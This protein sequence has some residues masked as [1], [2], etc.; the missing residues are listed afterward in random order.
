MVTVASRLL[1]VV[2]ESSS[3]RL[4]HSGDPCLEMSGCSG[5]GEAFY[6][7]WAC[8]CAVLPAVVATCRAAVENLKHGYRCDSGASGC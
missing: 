5:G 3:E 8:S 1:E 6:S 4:A 2:Q 7:V